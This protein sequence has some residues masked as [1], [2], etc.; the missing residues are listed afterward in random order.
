M[1]TETP[2]STGSAAVGEQLAGSA[3]LAVAWVALEQN[4]PWGPKAFTDSHLDPD[5]GRKLE[6]LA[7]EHQVRPCLIRS[8]GRH[9]DKPTAGEHPRRVL[10][11][12]TR[13]GAGTRHCTRAGAQT[14]TLWPTPL[15][16]RCRPR[17]P[18]RS[19]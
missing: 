18:S 4:G 8:P 9:A 1:S 12:F 15:P 6:A 11:A 10:V 13:P 2:C 14:I 16:T 5:V 17:L 19:R 7:A 3:P